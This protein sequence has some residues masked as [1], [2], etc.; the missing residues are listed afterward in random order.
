M[1]VMVVR[2]EYRIGG[3]GWYW[4]SRRNRDTYDARYGSGGRQE[5]CVY[6]DGIRYSVMGDGW[7]CGAGRK[8]V[9]F[10]RG[11]W[12]WGAYNMMYRRDG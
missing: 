6:T 12:Y 7:Y 1:F 5:A 2:V 9:N 4:A 3:V 10:D 8:R 11:W